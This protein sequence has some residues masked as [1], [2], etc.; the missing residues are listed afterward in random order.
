V[1]FSF[2]YIIFEW[3][4]NDLPYELLFGNANLN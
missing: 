3:F 2:I 4:L 1:L